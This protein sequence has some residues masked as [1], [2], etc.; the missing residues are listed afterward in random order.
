MQVKLDPYHLQIVAHYLKFKEDYLN[1]IQVKKH[2]RFL[3]D[4]FRINP[5]KITKETKNLFQY[6]DTQQIFG[7]NEPLN[8]Y[9]S[10]DIEALVDENEIILPN[11]KIIHY[12]YRHKG[13]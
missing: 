11:V 10:E 7:K 8:Y 13:R 4:R 2:F 1:I 5:I 6:L 12:N 3:L 9:S